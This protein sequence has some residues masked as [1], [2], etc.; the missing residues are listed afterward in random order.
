MNQLTINTAN[1]NRLLGTGWARGANRT[2][3]AGSAR[4]MQS[5]GHHLVPPPF[6]RTMIYLSAISCQST[7]HLSKGRTR[8][9]NRVNSSKKRN[10]ETLEQ[11]YKIRYTKEKQNTN[12]EWKARKHNRDT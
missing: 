10:Q 7:V 5:S 2:K 12:Y 4:V 6:P 8:P 9:K 1:T 3:T 11:Y